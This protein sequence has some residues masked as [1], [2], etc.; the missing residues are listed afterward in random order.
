MNRIRAWIRNLLGF[1]RTETNGFLILLPLMV[2]ILLSEP[3]YQWWYTSQPIDLTQDSKMLDSL[4]AQWKWNNPDSVSKKSPQF[5]TFNPNTASQEI[6]TTL[7]MDEKL[8][9]RIINYRSKGGKFKIKKDLAKIYGMDSTFFRSLYSFIDLPEKYQVKESSPKNYLTKP[10][11][12]AIAQ[13]DINL[14]DT[15]QLIK[16]YGIGTKLSQR[17][18]N[19]R[20]RLGGFIVMDQI[21]EV[22]GLD[23]AVIGNLKKRIFIA[24]DFVPRKI[25]INRIDEKQLSSHPYLKYPL[26]K[27]IAAYRF[28]HGEFTQLE[29]LK[30]IVTMDESTFEKIKPYLTVKD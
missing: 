25:N 30:A 9:H 2:L 28:Q 18:I 24:P 5:F 26:A 13:F 11:S 20:E 6:F 12:T 17:L 19:Y 3:L 1:S 23:S 15:S 7:G 10:S 16:I 29:D 14:A 4:V 21:S 8:A 27:A 22:Y